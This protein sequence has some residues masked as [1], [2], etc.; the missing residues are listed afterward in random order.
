MGQYLILYRVTTTGVSIMHIV[1]G[2][3]SLQAL[4]SD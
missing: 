3:R 4:F 1:H 2:R